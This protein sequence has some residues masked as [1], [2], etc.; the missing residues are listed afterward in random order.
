MKASTPSPLQLKE[1]K[2]ARINLDT[3]DVTGDNSELHFSHAISSE[4]NRDTRELWLVRVDVQIKP[5]PE[6]G[7]APYLGEVVMVGIFHLDPAFPEEKAEKMVCFN[8]GSILYGAIRELIC[9]ITS[10]GIHGPILLPTINANTF[11]P[12]SQES[13]SEPKSVASD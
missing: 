1:H 7:A 9:S 10:R 12:E 5:A 2:I 6:A 11:V 13:P 3:R 4:Q 8:G